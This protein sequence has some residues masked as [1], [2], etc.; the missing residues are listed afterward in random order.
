MNADQLRLFI[1]GAFASESQAKAVSARL[2]PYQAKL[3]SDIRSVV[4]RLPQESL[5]RVKD[6]RTLFQELTRLMGPYSNA[7]LLELDSQLPE[8]GFRAAEETIEQLKSVGVSMPEYVSPAAYMKPDDNITRLFNTKVQNQSLAEL[9]TKGT[10]EKSNL[11]TIN[12]IVT[13]GIIEGLPT[14]QIVKR[15]NESMP[16]HLQSQSQAIARTAIQDYNRQV[17][18][19]V[20]AD[21][22][23][24]LRGLQYEWVAALDSRTCPTCAPLD[25]VVKDKKSDFPDTPVHTNCRCVVVIVD[26]DS[27]A[28][29]RVGQQV[30]APDEDMPAEGGYKTKK[31]V[32]GQ[33]LRR[34]NKGIQPKQGKS[35]TYG[36]FLAGSNMKTQQMF[37]G[38]GQP[39]ANR[40]QD[41]RDY[42]KNGMEPKDALLKMTNRVQPSETK[43]SRRGVQRRFVAVST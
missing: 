25:G 17:K 39:G 2:T 20:W 19:S 33:K 31:A 12:R 8:A 41:F 34:F 26:P 32:K 4:E 1:N 5:T 21:N 36:D 42:L 10:F 9:F 29:M 6:W 7:F 35:V 13:G 16:K 28:N 3:L 11:R 30:L 27:E 43:R 22:S 37:F 14:P 24:A 15:L 18:E 40:A 38:G 23:D